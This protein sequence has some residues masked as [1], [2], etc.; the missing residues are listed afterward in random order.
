M[1]IT[2]L[3]GYV[4]LIIQSVANAELRAAR[5]KEPP[6]L[7]EQFKCLGKLILILTY[8]GHAGQ[9]PRF[10]HTLTQPISQLTLFFIGLK[11]SRIF[12][13]SP[14]CASNQNQR[15]GGLG[16]IAVFF[17]EL[18]RLSDF[19]QSFVYTP[20]DDVQAAE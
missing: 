19:I 4:G 3:P 1:V 12:S 10:H 17:K 18:V 13:L 11:R 7:F 9:C 8:D 16:L 14:L 2:H 15:S 6:A 5:L 20:L